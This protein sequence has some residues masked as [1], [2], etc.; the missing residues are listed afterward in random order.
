MTPPASTDSPTDAKATAQALYDQH[1]EKLR[2]LLVGMWNTAVSYIVF[3]LALKYLGPSIAALEGS[4]STLVSLIG[5]YYYLVIQWG[6]WVLMVVHST[7]TMKYIAFRSPGHLGKQIGRAYGVYFPAQVLSAAI[8]WFTVKILGLHPAVGQLVTVIFATVFSYLG[9]KYFTFEQPASRLESEEWGSA[10]EAELAEERRAEAR[11]R[12]RRGEPRALGAR[13]RLA[14]AGV[15][16]GQ[17]A[18]RL[19]A[20]SCAPAPRR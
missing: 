11:S 10:I 18:A 3:V 4:P 13:G 19:R 5:H 9:H 15:P 17:A 7:T 20:G 6:V 14:V 2:Y 16:S 1:G 12:E 8:L